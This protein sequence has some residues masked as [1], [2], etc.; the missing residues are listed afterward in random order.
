MRPEKLIMCAFGPYAGRV[1]VPF[2]EFGTHGIYLITGDTGAGKT[3]IFDGIV[4]ALYG[5]ASGDTRRPDMLRSDFADPKE[6]TYVELIFSCRGKSYAVTR[7]PEYLRPKTRGEGMTKESAD[8]SLV[9]PDG[10][11][12]TG[13]RQTTKAVEELLGIDRNQFVQIAMIAQG[14]FL[15]LLLAG[16]EERGRIFRKI[17]DT[18]YYLEFQ[19]ELKRRLLETKKTYEDLQRSV[20]Q[21][22]EGIVL[23]E[24]RDAQREAETLPETGDGYRKSEAVSDAEFSELVRCLD[25]LIHSD[26]SY[27]LAELSDCLGKLLDAEKLRQKENQQTLDTLEKRLLA[28][29]EQLGRQQMAQRARQ[30]IGRK[31]EL[32]ASLVREETECKAAF[33]AAVQN[34]PSVEKTAQKIT[35]LQRQME[36]YD[37]LDRM[38]NLLKKLQGKLELELKNSVSFGKSAELLEKEMAEGEARLKEIGEPKQALLLL[39]AEEDRLR[40]KKQELARLE[41]LLCTTDAQQ[42]KLRRTEAQ[43]VEARSRST[44]LGKKYVDM[45]AAFLSGQA[46]IL[47]EALVDGWPCPVCGAREHPVPAK[48]SAQI[49]SEEEL[50]KLSL[51]KEQAVAYT[52][53]IS[54]ILAAE[55][56]RYEQ[57]WKSVEDW[58]EQKRM[59]ENLPEMQEGMHH[60]QI[61]DGNGIKAYLKQSR[62]EITKAEKEYRKKRQ[63]LERLVRDRALLEQR[64]P[65]L[66]GQRDQLLQSREQSERQIVRLQTEISGT[67]EHRAKLQGELP[68]QNRQEAECVLGRLQAE[69]RRMEQEIT[70]SRERLEQCRIRKAS[71]EKALESLR[72]QAS[73]AGE[74]ISE[75]EI[76]AEGMAVTQEKVQLEQDQKQRHTMILTNERIFRQLCRSRETLETA[77]KNYETIALLSDTANGELKGRQKLAFE[78]YIQ[79]VFFRQIIHE[80]NKRFSVMTDGRYLLKRRE[81][82]GNLRSQT[83]LELNVFD[84]YTGKLRSVQSLSGGESFKASLSMALGLA[85]VVQQYAGGIQLDAIFIDEGFGSLDRE[86]LNQAIRILN[87]LAGENRLAGIISHVD[88]LKDR[89]DR[90]IVVT[91]GTGGSSVA[92]IKG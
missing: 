82:P 77:E 35:I 75:E 9:C 84:Y 14:D 6:K 11:I 30:E 73:H 22:A 53:Q 5:E 24:S 43:F 51:E 70:I 48:K 54:G 39:E 12:I 66:L 42:E 25:Q 33:E 67:T 57:L 26:V 87:E 46:G 72:M 90:K 34:Q 38:I 76:R 36:Q 29:R 23:P 65:Q 31:Q 88:E 52:T 83:G 15:R 63:E 8:A 81:E 1:E 45:E 2:S 28:L 10:K 56:A 20:A 64:L 37:E 18:G 32:L 7:N 89:I 55:R 21:Y 19:K 41:K 60:E 13:S 71:E 86:S 16:T 79:I 49:P 91:K 85:D 74:Q 47:A 69:R 62:E 44:I 59:E 17:F 80:A 58:W 78:Q 68:Y 61:P 3:T 4:F 27:H 40:L 92:V 50:K